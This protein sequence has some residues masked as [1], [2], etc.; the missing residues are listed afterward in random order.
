MRHFQFDWALVLRVGLIASVAAAFGWAGF[1]VWV[2]TAALPPLVPETSSVVVDRH[3]RLLRAYQVADGRWRL[4]VDV[5]QVDQGY[6]KQLIAYEDRRFGQH[7]GVDPWALLR[8]AGQAVAGGPPRSGASTLSM[9]VARLLTGA[10]TRTLPRK[11]RQIRLAL[12]LERRLSKAQVLEL[13]L[14]L[15][16]FGGNVEGV[17]AA[18]LTWFAKEP[19]RLTPAEAA[20]LVALPQAPEWRRPDRHPEAARRA[21]D[22]VLARS[23]AA[24]ALAADEAAAARSELVPSQRRPFLHHGAHLADRLR[25]ARPAEA[26]VRTTI[27]RDVQARIERLLVDTVEHFPHAMSGAILVADHGTGEI[28]A[29]VGSPGLI[30]DARQGFNDMTLAVR[31]P[32]SLLKPLIYGLAFAEGIAHPESLIEDR[33]TAFGIYAPTNFDDQYRGAISVRRALQQSRNVPAVVL[34]DALGPA[35]FMARMRRAGVMPVVPSGGANLA[36]GLGGLGMSLRDIVTVYTAFARDGR[37]VPLTAEP[38]QSP[39]QEVRIMSSAAAW[40]VTDVLAGVRAPS[41]ALN[42]RL[43]FKTG[44]SYGYRDAWAIGYDGRH[45]I[46]VWVGRADAAPVP[47]ITGLNAAAPLLFDAF[48]RLKPRLEP[49]VPP[50]PEVLVAANWE[51]PRP[52]QRVRGRR[53]QRPRSGPEVAFPPD[54]ARIETAGGPLALKVRDGV[55]PFTWLVN[56]HPVATAM[57]DRQSSWQPDSAGFASIAVVDAQGA[58]ARADVFVQ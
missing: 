9:Q 51:L 32:G 18:A 28:L 12:A 29:S 48:S 21:R 8:A 1:E 24:G 34:L 5:E 52:L 46:G 58:A 19:Q 4:P 2:R 39:P 20:L 26:V 38:R 25:Q 37:V 42:G 53:G 56:G 15:A 40:H 55:P 6:I 23:V 50:P 31:S 3:G 35:R 10:P 49:F 41:G 30:D 57:L 27:D 33:P 14:M 54:G 36:I 7:A 11:L 22:R 16:P 45:V 17:R 43:A 44:T 47:G 13:Y